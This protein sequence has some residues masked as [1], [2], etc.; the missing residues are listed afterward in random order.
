[1]KVVKRA[2][3]SNEMWEMCRE[4][5]VVLI[6]K[7]RCDFAKFIYIERCISPAHPPTSSPAQLGP[8][9]G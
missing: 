5:Y 6:N 7:K 3:V 2:V 9:L 4:M 1:M 8:F